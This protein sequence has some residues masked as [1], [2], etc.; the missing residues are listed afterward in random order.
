[1]DKK[2]AVLAIVVVFTLLLTAGTAAALPLDDVLAAVRYRSFGNTGGN[3]IYLGVGDLGV[4]ANRVEKG[5]TWV[6]PES[7]DVTFTYVPDGVNSKLVTTGDFGTLT[8]NLSSPLGYMNA[9]EIIVADRDA[10]SQVNFTNV[11]LTTLGGSI[12]I[13]GD[14]IGNNAFAFYEYMNDDLNDGFT[15]TGTIELSGPFSFSQEL[16]RVEIK[17]GKVE[18]PEPA[19]ILL[20]GTGLFGLVGLRKKFRK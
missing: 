18:V 8:Y 15:F 1:M 14:F 17:V 10:D 9:F 4:A 20:I 7:Y 12:V 2:K 13:L 19:T 11:S 5:F 6:K 16:S 3:E